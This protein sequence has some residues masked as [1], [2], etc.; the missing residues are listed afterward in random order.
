MTEPKTVFVLRLTRSQ[1]M[2]LL[3]VLTEHLQCPGSTEIFIDCS[4]MPPTET[5]V[6]DL[7]LRLSNLTEMEVADL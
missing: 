6:S 7:L 5:T 1:Q 4:T 2:A 3:D